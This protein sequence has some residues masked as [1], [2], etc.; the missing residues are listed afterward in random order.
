[1]DRISFVRIAKD[2]ETRFIHCDDPWDYGGKVAA[3]A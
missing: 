3:S 1:M 2:Y